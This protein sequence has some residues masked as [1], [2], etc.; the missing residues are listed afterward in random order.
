MYFFVSAVFPHCF[1][2]LYL[3]KTQ[4]AQDSSVWST[5][6]HWRGTDTASEHPGPM[7]FLCFTPIYK[8]IFKYKQTHLFFLEG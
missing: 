4:S 7:T 6:Q 8:W 3:L 2:D 1:F 5:A